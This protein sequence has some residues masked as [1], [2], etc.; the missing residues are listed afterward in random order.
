MGQG[1][2]FFAKAALVALAGSI[3]SC[4]SGSPEP[5]ETIGSVQ[6]EIKVSNS[7]TM[8]DQDGTKSFRVTAQSVQIGGMWI[9]GVVTIDSTGST[10]TVD[11]RI[12]VAGS[13]A[14][15]ERITASRDGELRIVVD[16]K[17]PFTGIRRAVMTSSDSETGIFEIDGRLSLPTVL[18]GGALV[19][20]DGKPPPVLKINDRQ[21]DAMVELVQ[22][23]HGLFQDC[24]TP[25]PK[26]NQSPLVQLPPLTLGVSGGDGGHITDPANS[27]ECFE[28][29][30][31]CAAGFATCSYIAG[32][33]STLC[34]PF[35][36]LCTGGGIAACAGLWVVGCNDSCMNAGPCC[37]VSCGGNNLIECCGVGE[38]CLGTT[39]NP[40]LAQVCCD[41]GDTPC[42]GQ[43]C[44]SPD[45]ACTDDGSCCA[46]EPC[47]TTCCR[48]P[49]A[50]L[51]YCLDPATSTCC[52][53]TREV[54]NGVCCA[55]GQI[56]DPNGFCVV[57]PPP[58]QT[59]QECIDRDLNGP[60]CIEVADCP[61][62]PNAYN[63][64]FAGCCASVR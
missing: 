6:D 59:E 24:L 11:K 5:A 10:V 62:D 27:A 47:G 56:C 41:P 30:A 55:L 34:G 37:P 44:C 33:V 2:K 32:V 52:D 23:S 42:Q 19:F 57:P 21:R 15:H 14:Y 38:P 63:Q 46:D 22:T 58:A 49:D 64:C 28:C 61:D 9:E 45:E 8:A 26:Q 29:Y 17:G 53:S 16:Y 35:V 4:S 60:T 36:L 20:E 54:C 43:R 50:P 51:G 3:G 48:G 25:E 40:T 31:L 12:H 7:C 18:E 1:G 13:E 39:L